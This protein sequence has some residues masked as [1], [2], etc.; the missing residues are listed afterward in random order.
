V[1]VRAKVSVLL[2]CSLLFGA[3]AASTASARLVV[4]IGDE[5]ALMFANPF[6]QQLGVKRTRVIAP[7]DSALH[8]SPK[9]DLWMENAFLAG[10][11]IVV[12]FNPSSGSNCPGQPC[13]APSAAQFSKAFKAFHARYK[14]VKI[15]QPWNEVNSVTQPTAHHPEL[16]V[17]YYALVRKYCRGCTVLG[18]DLEDLP[19]IANGHHQSNGEVTYAKKLL[20][21]FKSAHVSTPHLWGLHN[22]VD[23]N[24]FHSTG[25]RAALKVLPGQIWLTE[26]GGIAYFLVRGA[27]KPKLPFD[28]SRQARATDWM[29]HLALSNRRITRVYIYNFFF[30]PGNRFDSALL[31]GSGQPRPAWTTLKTNWAGFF[32]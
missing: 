9:L 24:Y 15:F 13:R 5:S 4:G 27:I 30:S 28:L 29:M 2:A 3:V 7:Y 10:E 26:T 16:V 19:D 11:Q 21:D 22:Y 17:R 6:F 32:G 1:N 31:D 23:V 12:A 18:A 25:T 8:S 20:K 14:F